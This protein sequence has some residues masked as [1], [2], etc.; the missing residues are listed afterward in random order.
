MQQRTRRRRTAPKAS[1]RL[2]INGEPI[3][4]AEAVKASASGAT[5]RR[6]QVL[7]KRPRSVG[8]TGDAL[9]PHVLP[10][11]VLNRLLGRLPTAG[12]RR[13]GVARARLFTIAGAGRAL[14]AAGL[15]LAADAV[16]ALAGIAARAGLAARA[17]TGSLL[18]RGA[19][20]GADRAGSATRTG[21][22]ASAVGAL[23]GCV[24]R[25]G[26]LAE[27]LANGLVRG[28]ASARGFTLACRLARTGFQ[29]VRLGGGAQQRR[30]NNQMRKHRHVSLRD[31][32]KSDSQER[33][34]QAERRLL[35]KWSR[36]R[37]GFAAGD[38]AGNAPEPRFPERVRKT[39][40]QRA[41]MAPQ[42]GG[43]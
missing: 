23:A 9:S 24:A 34:R 31:C 42:R 13:T 28:L 43:T 18:H 11:L 15:G 35:I 5:S 29:S 30:D 25:A 4:F 12:V 21:L 17:R 14:G 40:D 1:V 26:G 39:R 41:R 38:Q 2:S 27:A 37:T 33:T 36:C 10:V 32:R 6:R 16:G 3:R 19:L 7:E 8:R 22:A 20:S